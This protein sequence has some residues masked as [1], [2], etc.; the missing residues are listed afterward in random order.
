MGTC[1][2]GYE[3][4]GVLLRVKLV[5]ELPFFQHMKCEEVEQA[6]SSAMPAS[7]EPGLP[8]F[9]TVLLR[10]T[11]AKVELLLRDFVNLESSGQCSLFYVNCFM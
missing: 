4:K 6:P 7:V 9:V 2:K 1:K 5:K 8:A 3:G 10:L 11:N